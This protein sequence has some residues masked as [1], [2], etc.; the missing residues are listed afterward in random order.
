MFFTEW[1]HLL[2]FIII[3][4]ALLIELKWCLSDWLLVVTKKKLYLQLILF[5]NRSLFAHKANFPLFLYK[6]KLKYFSASFMFSQQLIN[7]HYLSSQ[8]MPIPNRFYPLLTLVRKSV[9]WAI[10]LKFKYSQYTSL[11]LNR[12]T[13]LRKVKINYLN[14]MFLL[15]ECMILSS[16]HH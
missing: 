4:Y 13:S 11:S 6:W 1:F 10:S 14:K 7:I 16:I 9:C 8:D 2:F 3:I 5:A 15:I 12:P